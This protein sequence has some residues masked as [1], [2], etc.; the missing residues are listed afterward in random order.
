MRYEDCEDGRP[1][2]PGGW[3]RHLCW[4]LVRLRS[5]EVSPQVSTVAHQWDWLYSSPSALDD[6]RRPGG[7]HTNHLKGPA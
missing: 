5:G 3:W 1:S 6:S 4:I 2:D 7:L